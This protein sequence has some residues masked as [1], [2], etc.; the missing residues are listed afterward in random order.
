MSLL[1]DLLQ[2]CNVK[3]VELDE[4][5][6]PLAQHLYLS[7]SEFHSLDKVGPF[8][9]E[10]RAVTIGVDKLVGNGWVVG[11]AAMLNLDVF[12]QRVSGLIGS[13]GLEVG[14][15]LTS[16][17]FKIVPI[18]RLTYEKE[19]NKF[20]YGASVQTSTGQIATVGHGHPAD[21]RF[22]ASAGLAI[23]GKC[24]SL[25]ASYQGTLD[26]SDGNEDAFIGRLTYSF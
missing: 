19:L 16:D 14:G 26:Y 9:Y 22:V 25:S 12:D 20:D 4:R 7:S 24:L 17:R 10:V 15:S 18:V 8:D 3:A 21:D 1:P 23:V 13:V 5:L 6:L 2:R 11:A